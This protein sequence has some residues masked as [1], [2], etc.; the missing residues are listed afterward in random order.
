[1]ISAGAWER[2]FGSDPAIVGKSVE[3][4]RRPYVI[5]G[6]L[7]RDFGIPSRATDFWFAL[8]PRPGQG[9]AQYGVVLATLA[10]GVSLEAA[11]EEANLIGPSL[12]A[13]AAPAMNFGVPS[14][15]APPPTPR[16]AT[17]G[18][19]ATPVLTNAPRFQVLS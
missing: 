3:L 11:T 18:G 6:V 10:P 12:Q 14:S 9:S 1:V 17:M 19:P 13:A 2:L 7:P 8:T 16:T 5:V 4:S 15:A